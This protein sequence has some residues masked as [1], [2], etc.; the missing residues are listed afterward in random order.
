MHTY[1]FGVEAIRDKVGNLA[2][3]DILIGHNGAEGIV[4]LPY[5]FPSQ[6]ISNGV[7]RTQY[8]NAM[9][10]HTIQPLA[11]NTSCLQCMTD[12]LTSFYSRPFQGMENRTETERNLKY[13]TEFIGTRNLFVL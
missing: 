10:G 11:T 1:R 4:M 12:M 13:S 8:H 2:S 5:I 6:D 7:T 9:Q 3:Y